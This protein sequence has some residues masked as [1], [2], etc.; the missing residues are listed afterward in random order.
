MTL[1]MLTY[2]CDR[3]SKWNPEK[4][5][6]RSLIKA[7]SDEEATQQ[8]QFLMEQARRTERDGWYNFKIGTPSL[9]RVDTLTTLSFFEG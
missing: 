7:E 5:V 6:C 9:Q 8:A 4:V 2:E 3:G 1:Y